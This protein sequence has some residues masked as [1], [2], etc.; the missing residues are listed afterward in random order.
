MIIGTTPYGAEALVALLLQAIVAQVSEREGVGPDL[1]V[2][3]HP[4]NYSDYKLGLLEEAARLA[5]LDLATVRFLSEPQAAAVAYASQR[6]V[7]AGDVVAVYDFGGGTF[8]AAVVRKE[9]GEGFS[10]LGHPE[11][12]DRLGGIDI[13]QAVLAHVDDAVGGMVTSIASGDPSSRADVGRL[14][15]EAQR[16]KEALSTDTDCTIAVS[17]PGL[18]TEVRLTRD[19]LEGMIRPRIAETIDALRRAVAS[20]GVPMDGVSRVLLV[21]G[22]SRIPLV[23]MLV[24]EAT[25]RPVAVDAHPK[26]AI[27]SGAAIV[28][29]AELEAIAAAGAA[30]VSPT[31]GTPTPPGTTPV[32]PS[33]PLVRTPGMARLAGVAGAGFLATAGA[34]AVIGAVG[35]AASAS[36]ASAPVGAALAGVGPAGTP[37]A[38]GPVGT[39]VSSAAPSAPAA[40]SGAAPPSPPAAPGPT[41]SGATPPPPPAG[42]GTGAT[43]PAAKAA[44]RR[45]P[46]AAAATVGVVAAVAAVVAVTSQSEDPPAATETSTTVAAQATTDPS[47]ATTSAEAGGAST[48]A[49][50]ARRGLPNK[51]TLLA[52]SRTDNSGAGVPGVA[53]EVSLGA[54]SYLGVS[55]GDALVVDNAL[56]RVIRVKDG[57]A[58][59]AYQGKGAIGG[60]AVGPT[61]KVVLL[62]PD[63]LLELGADGQSKVLATLA[64]LGDGMGSGLRAPMAFDG[65]GNL[66][67]ANNLRYQVLRRSVDGA[68]SLVAGNGEFA[69]AGGPKGDGGAATAAPIS[70]VSALLVDAKGNL[71]IGE[72]QGALRKVSATDGKLST[73]AGAGAT[74]LLTADDT[75]PPDGT[76][77]ADL[78]FAEV[79]ALTVDAK[80]RI[81]V[82]DSQAGAL[83]RIMPDGSI[84]I[85]AGDQFRT[86]EPSIEGEAANRTRLADAGGLA[87]ESS[88]ALLVLDGGRLVRIDA[89]ASS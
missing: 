10:L 84:E 74:K 28:G 65:A 52:G 61:G 81:Y 73:I 13:D 76:P 89:V 32:S 59:I 68:M 51:M 80:G 56:N 20:T 17:L 12:M 78:D 7:E 16:A 15:D 48:T 75:F 30:A 36:A 86:S 47:T 79:T 27:A 8:D 77:A 41:G 34:A 39:P 71:L 60:L 87:F 18:Q 85:L 45:L 37:T 72:A 53:T 21:G 46:V 22:S 66:Y 55:N 64:A 38:A 43:K 1:V 2:L 24:R 35:K 42:A 23:G 31:A 26:L 44:A 5:G 11:G 63:G 6:R 33:A 29:A 70:G 9:E 69:G 54:P 57:K 4:A 49:P 82:G 19:E 83:L 40:G 67:L 50:S 88:G 25:G 58:T 62:T 14:R 3:T